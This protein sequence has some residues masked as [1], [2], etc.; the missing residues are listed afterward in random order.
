LSLATERPQLAFQLEKNHREVAAHDRDRKLLTAPDVERWRAGDVDAAYDLAQDPGE[1]TN[2]CAEP[3]AAELARQLATLVEAALE[4]ATD[5]ARVDTAPE[6]L[7]DLQKI[8][9]DGDG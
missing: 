8:G 2:L 6:A 7:R 9:Y 1:A 3:W 4:P 5:P